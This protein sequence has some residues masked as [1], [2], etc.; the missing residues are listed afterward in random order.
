MTSPI[1]LF[2]GQSDERH[3]SV[4]SAQ[5]IVRTLGTPLCWFLAPDGAVHDAGPAE[6]LAH[7]RP[8]ERDFIPSRPA[9]WPD[10]EQALDTMPVDEPVLLL[11]LHGGAGEDGT[12]QRMIEAR[13]LPFT[14]SRS[15]ASAAAFDK[16]RTK[17]IVRPRV[18]VAESMVARD[19]GELGGVVDSMLVRHP[20]IVLKPVA[21][22]SSR[23]LFFLA[24]DGN[25]AAV[26]AE[27]AALR[28]PY[29]VEQFIAGREIT[30]GIVDQGDGPFALPCLE[31]EV[32][33]GFAFD[34]EGKYL[35]RGTREICPANIPPGVAAEAQR[36][37]LAAHL[38]LGC[39][40][41]SRSDLVAAPDGVYFLETNT[42]PGLT[43]SSLVPQQLRVAGI[44]F[45]E[46]L[47]GQV[48]LAVRRATSS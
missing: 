37:A 40:G 2:G 46:F 10:L 6:L 45:R 30:V 24:R 41:Y 36:S 14:G 9:V 15:E 18:R 17:E 33:P 19:A 13:G 32:D 34:Y 48:E 29:I 42:L 25:A 27:A 3:V 38:A 8:F 11:A 28:V 12:V 39:D 44:G 31:I 4:A 47:E 26:V 43:T 22:G 23:G 1:V 5:N 35:G 7:Q 21:G 20:K 16:A